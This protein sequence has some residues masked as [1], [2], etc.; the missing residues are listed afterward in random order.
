MNPDQLLTTPLKTHDALHRW[1]RLFCNID[2]PRQSV[3][4]HHDAPFDYLARAYFE[5]ARDQV[6]HAPRGGGK[7]RLA[8]VAT[9]LDL[10]HKPGVQVRILG[11]SLEQSM[12]MWEHLLPDLEGRAPHLLPA[13]GVRGRRVTLTNQSSVAVLTQS[14]RA[15]RGLRVQKIRCDEVELFKP[16][17]WEAAQLS[18]RSTR[19]ATNETNTLVSGAIEALSTLHNAGGLMQRVL[20]AAVISK[21]PVVKWCVLDVLERCEPQRDC[22]TCPL[23]DECRGRAKT[24]ASG[25]VRIDDAIRMKFRVSK[26]TWESEML[27]LRPAVRNAVFPYFDPQMHVRA[28]EPIAGATISLAV[29]FGFA[30]PL[31]C[32]WIVADDDGVKVLDEY[33]QPRRTVEEHLVHIDQRRW[34]RAGF[35]ACDP[36]G[37][38]Q[39]DQTASSN[40]QLL[41]AAGYEVRTRASRIVDGI[42]LIRRAIRPAQ[43]APTLVVHPRCEHLIKSLIGYRYP[44][45]ATGPSE[46]PAKDGIHD[47]ACDALRYWFVNR[48]AYE[49]VKVRSY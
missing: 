20:D 17:I 5:P 18:T 15:V 47:H 2:V 25:F 32:L 9:L 40:V 16:D 6:V 23:W 11:G 49:G 13:R 46:L 26:E 37:V 7:T 41:R 21:T 14:Q 33:V 43:G 27:C 29:D 34:P 36:A 30:A 48:R 38:G 28:F 45:L 1:V 35:I 8:A 12:K 42:E 39:N 44:E 4:E 31:V 22:T 24:H 3:C 10:L 19:S